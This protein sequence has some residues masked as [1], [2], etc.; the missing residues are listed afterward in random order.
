MSG[1]CRIY[2][3]S[4]PQDIRA[5]TQLGAESSECFFVMYRPLR[6]Q[7]NGRTVDGDGPAASSFS[8]DRRCH[9]ASPQHCPITRAL[10]SSKH[11]VVMLRSPLLVRRLTQMSVDTGQVATALKSVLEKAS[12]AAQKSGRN[13]KVGRQ[14]TSVSVRRLLLL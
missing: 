12:A 10:Q 13:T 1:T 4:L 5:G 6:Q 8:S 3:L 11:Q 14:S 7:W 2:L 9:R